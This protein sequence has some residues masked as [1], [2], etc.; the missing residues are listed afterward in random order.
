MKYDSDYFKYTCPML[1]LKTSFD[2]KDLW[3]GVNGAYMPVLFDLPCGKIG[4]ALDREVTD[5]LRIYDTRLPWL[6]T[7]YQNDYQGRR[8]LLKR[9]IHSTGLLATM[10]GFRWLEQGEG[11]GDATA[12][13]TTCQTSELFR[14]ES[15]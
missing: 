15:R 3:L 6:N 4:W 9:R 7:T 14:C 5:V 11:V 8:E 1:Y 12:W 13:V 10:P 2:S